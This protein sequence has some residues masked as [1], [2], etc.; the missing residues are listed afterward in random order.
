MRT[1]YHAG[2]DDAELLEGCRRR[3]R[4]AQQAVYERHAGRIYR[5]ALRLA[6]NEQ[7][8]FDL[9]Q[10]TFVRAFEKIHT[11][12][13]QARLS[14]WLCRIATNEA[15]QFFRR[16]QTERRHLRLVSAAR[17]QTTDDQ[18]A[19]SVEMDDALA[20]LSDEHR[21]ILVLRYQEGLSYADLA[22]AL[23]LSPGTVASRLNRARAE[24]RALLREDSPAGMEE[25]LDGGHPTGENNKKSEAGSR[26]PAAS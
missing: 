7:D 17:V 25:N 24:L 13:A 8:A 22:E 15:L 19:A 2:M 26:G 5:L 23:A 10:E 20:A 12:D 21:A 9:A 11:F 1:P 14:T 18:T 6:G 3:D 16:R 4:R